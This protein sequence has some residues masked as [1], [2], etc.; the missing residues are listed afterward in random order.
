MKKTVFSKDIVKLVDITDEQRMEVLTKI[1]ETVTKSSNLG[2]ETV[3][4]FYYSGD[5]GVAGPYNWQM[6]ANG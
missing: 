1:T 2:E 4:L 5:G 6:Q 3:V